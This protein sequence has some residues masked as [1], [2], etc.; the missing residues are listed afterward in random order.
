M[1]GAGI[2]EA[3]KLTA[4]LPMGETWEGWG[5]GLV[6]SAITGMLAIRFLLAHLQKDSF[7]PF[8]IY[9]ILLGGTIAMFLII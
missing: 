5:V 8:V 2:F 1:L 4:G 3:R 7:V 9:R 6:L